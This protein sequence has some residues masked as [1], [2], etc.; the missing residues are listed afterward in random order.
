[1]FGRAQEIGIGPMSGAS[2][3][4]HWLKAHGHTP[5]DA[6]VK[7]ILARAKQSNHLLTDAEIREVVAAH[8]R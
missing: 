4:N 3:V 2:N 6:L 5:D 7:A 8:P 1:M